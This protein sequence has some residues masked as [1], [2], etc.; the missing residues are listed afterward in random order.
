MSN[1]T[2]AYEFDKPTGW[3]TMPDGFRFNP[4]TGENTENL[5]LEQILVYNI[6]RWGKD[7]GPQAPLVPGDYDFEALAGEY[8]T[9]QDRIDP[10]L[11]RLDEI[12]AAFKFMSY[13]THELAGLKVS[14]ARSSRLDAAAFA[15]RYPVE[16]HPQFYKSAPDSTS[17]KKHLA[18]AE[19]EELSNAG[20]PR[21]TIK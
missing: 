20:D 5:T 4:W 16:T 7:G 9:I 10:D 2:P 8:A 12:K 3:V 15:N 21:V 6:E 14:L 13:G 19:I 1:T 11:K 18:P 17:I